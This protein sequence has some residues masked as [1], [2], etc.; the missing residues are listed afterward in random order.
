[1]NSG[2]IKI[3]WLFI[4][5]LVALLIGSFYAVASR[6]VLASLLSLILAAG[7]VYSLVITP[8]TKSEA[9]NLAS[10]L[11]VLHAA[12]LSYSGWC[13]IGPNTDSFN[14][15]FLFGIWPALVFAW[16]LWLIALP[17]FWRFSER[18]WAKLLF[19][20]GLGVLF[21]LPA[22]VYLAVMYAFLSHGPG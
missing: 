21:L 17:I 14:K 1:M 18:K 10:I 20:L 8:M 19:P 6:S 11:C 12:F 22:L 16:P 7:V 9:Y 3:R 5:A 4:I 15:A 13:L 2:T